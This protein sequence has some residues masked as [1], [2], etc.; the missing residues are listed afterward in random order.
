MATANMGIYKSWAEGST[1]GSKSLI[2]FCPGRTYIIQQQFL[3]SAKHFQSAV[4]PGGRN[5]NS[6]PS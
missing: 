1:I 6:Q 5:A 4:V 3:T 2:N